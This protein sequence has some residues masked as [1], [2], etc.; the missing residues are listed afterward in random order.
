MN[1]VVLTL[2]VAV[3][4]VCVWLIVRIINRREPWAKWTLVAVVVGVPV[5]Y[6]LSFGPACWWFTVPSGYSNVDEIL[7]A[8]LPPVAAHQIYWPIGWLATHGPLSIERLLAW[9][10]KLGGHEVLVPTH[11]EEGGWWFP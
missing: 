11:A 8:P 10:A 5:V 1:I 4:A 9:Y 6:V 2:A 7:G 3:A